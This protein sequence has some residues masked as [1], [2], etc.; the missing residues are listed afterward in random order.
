MTD[1]A[2]D[3][4]RQVRL[5]PI[6]IKMLG[7]LAVQGGE[8]DWWPMADKPAVQDINR[9]LDLMVSKHLV[10]FISPST[11][12][13]ITQSLAPSPVPIVSAHGSRIRV[14]LT[15]GGRAVCAQLDAMSMRPK[16]QV[17]SAS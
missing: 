15:D 16:V 1:F 13:V 8:G 3:H 11:R 7:Q 9:C 5:S 14:R 12:V 17:P 6:E 10:E 2:L 4:L